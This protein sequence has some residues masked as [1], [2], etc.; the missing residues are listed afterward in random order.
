[1]SE[2]KYSCAHNSVTKLIDNKIQELN[3]KK[4]YFQVS[5]QILLLEE[6]KKE[7]SRLKSKE[8]SIC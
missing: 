2:P 8:E 4:D 6:L 3:S 5:K 7:I 1:M